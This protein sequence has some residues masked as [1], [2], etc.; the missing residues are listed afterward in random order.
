MMTGT[1]AD[2]ADGGAVGWLAAA[3]CCSGAVGT[4]AT[5]RSCDG[6]PRWATVFGV[7]RRANLNAA[8]ASSITAFGRRPIREGWP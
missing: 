2:A 5:C 7:I 6:R 8:D 3:L 4:A 1:A